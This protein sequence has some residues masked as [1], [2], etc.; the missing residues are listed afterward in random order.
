MRNKSIDVTP[1][2]VTSL[3]YSNNE[4]EPPPLF[5]QIEICQAWLRDYARPTKQIRRRFT[6]DSFRRLVTEWTRCLGLFTDR[7]QLNVHTGESYFSDRVYVSNGA[8]IAAALAEGYRAQRARNSY[9]AWFNLRHR[10][11]GKPW[12]GKAPQAFA[13]RAAAPRDRLTRFLVRRG[14]Q[15]FTLASAARCGASA[16]A[17][18]EL[19]YGP[20]VTRVKGR[21]RSLWFRGA[22]RPPQLTNLRQWAESK[23]CLTLKEAAEV[24]GLTVPRGRAPAS[25]TCTLRALGF[26]AHRRRWIRKSS[27]T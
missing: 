1:L 21:Q 11:I 25:L 17:L 19:G 22:T 26:R 12:R 6:S 10:G 20:K 24:A 9:D 8:F 15:P 27:E 18:R 13:T 3:G 14:A 4:N 7:E 2:R 23:T 16:H 5:A